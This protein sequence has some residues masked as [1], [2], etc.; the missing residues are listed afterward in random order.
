M[1]ITMFRA[2]RMIVGEEK[3]PLG[4]PEE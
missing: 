3:V 1:Y 4:L 2:M